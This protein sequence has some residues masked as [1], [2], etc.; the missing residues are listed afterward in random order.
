VE[1]S[2][3]DDGCGMDAATREKAFE[4]FYTTKE[5]GSGTGLGLSTVQGI[6]H[7]SGGSVELDSELEKG[8]TIR[9][10]LPAERRDERRGDPSEAR[11]G[12]NP[13]PDS[14]T[15]LLAED[16]PD[17]RRLAAAALRSAGYE[18][19]E[20]S[21]GVEALE[22]ARTRTRPIHLVVS[23]LIMPRMGGAEL[24]DRLLSI[25]PGL[26]VLLISGY[27]GDS[28]PGADERTHPLLRKP[29]TGHALVAEARR[30]LDTR[31][32]RET[33]KP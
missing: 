1:L 20:A 26:G 27:G 10:I 28:P 11:P 17:V 16:E 18:V 25:T 32:R 14:E 22:V 2:V 8:T 23:D 21:D 19:I 29:F 33:D 30:V 31:P 13:V 3:S 5:V 4:P 15:V 6:V 9:I 12:T 7:Q 24:A